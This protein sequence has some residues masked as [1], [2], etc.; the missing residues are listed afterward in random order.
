MDWK[1]NMPIDNIIRW[2][3]HIHQYPEIAF[4]EKETAAY[5]TRELSKISGIEILHPT[6]TSVIGILHGVKQGKTIAFRADIDALEIQEDSGLEFMSKNEGISHACGHDCHAAMLLGVAKVLSGQREK[7]SGTVK[8]IFQHAEEKPPGGAIEIINS[9]ALEDV[10][11]I[12]GQHVAIPAPL[13]MVLTKDGIH[14][15]SQD[16]FDIS[17]IGKSCHGSQP[18]EGIDPITIGAEVVSCLN[19]ILSKNINAQEPAVLSLG[20]FTAGQTHNVVPDMAIIKGNIRTFSESVRQTVMARIED[21][22]AGITSAFN[23]SY[24]IKWAGYPSMNHNDEANQ[25]MRESAK[26]IVGEKMVVTMPQPTPSSEDFANY[27]M[28][29]KGS[30]Y[31]LGFGTYDQGAAGVTHNPEFKVNEDGLVIGSKI[32]VQIAMDILGK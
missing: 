5:I 9:G 8:F 6:E 7:L 15:A 14:S 27:E 22:V 21:I 31:F 3:R 11:Y 12:F 28:V 19:S 24:R 32:F 17:I 13:G 18:H 23:T 29:T 30:Y 20:Q 2:R 26:K 25:I 10:D 4:Q 16:I 1:Q